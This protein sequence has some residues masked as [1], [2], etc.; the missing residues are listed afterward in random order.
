MRRETQLRAN[1]EYVRNL[2]E[3]GE[4]LDGRDFDEFRDIELEAGYIRETADGSAYVEMGD[5]KLIVGISTE[6]GE[7]YD[8]SPESGTLITNA[9][10]GPMASE[11]W[12]AGPP[13]IEAVELARVVDRGIRE[14]GIIDLE[15]LGIEEGEKCWLLFV[16]IHVLDFDGNLIDASFLGA[17]AALHNGYLPEYDEEEDELDREEDGEPIPAEGIPVTLTGRKI[18]DQILVDTTGEEED[19]ETSRLTVTLDDD[20][21]LVSLQKGEGSSMSRDDA[22]EIIEMTEERSE[23]LRSKVEDAL[24]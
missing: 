15:D 3:D 1:Q 21:N 9:E 6:L 23:F 17:I 18:E 8:D 20:D 13:T 2:V 4:R 14:S 10:L 24:E 12:E 5:T 19:V 16:D 22:L 7:P 11:D